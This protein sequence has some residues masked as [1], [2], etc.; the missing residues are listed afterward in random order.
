MPVDKQEI[1]VI[2]GESRKVYFGLRNVSAMDA[3]NYEL[4]L[5]YNGIKLMPGTFTSNLDHLLILDPGDCISTSVGTKCKELEVTLFGD[6]T[7]DSERITL[8]V[9]QFKIHPA[10]NMLFPFD[11]SKSY[12]LQNFTIRVVGEL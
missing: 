2:R 3:G 12:Q 6:D 9:L 5:G 10:F 4:G 8:V 1:E 11:E 7:L